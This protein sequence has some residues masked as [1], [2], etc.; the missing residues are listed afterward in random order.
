MGIAVISEQGASFQDSAC[1]RGKATH[2][3]THSLG[4]HLAKTALAEHH[5]EVE[6]SQLHAIL[7][8]VG[9]EPGRGVGRFTV[10]VLAWAD[11]GPLDEEGKTGERVTDKRQTHK[12]FRGKHR[13]SNKFK[14]A[15]VNSNDNEDRVVG[16]VFCD[17]QGDLG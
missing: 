7:V 12:R 13:N 11:L 9:V 15:S 2:T 14:R 17:P 4:A 16:W 1:I 8:A 5:Q 6:V 10:G 3:H